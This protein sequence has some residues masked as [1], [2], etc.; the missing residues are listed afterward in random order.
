MRSAEVVIEN[1]A[2]LHSRPG[3]V[4][5]ERAKGWVSTIRIENLSRGA[6][7]VD[8]KSILGLLT[9]GASRGHRM[10]LTVDGADEELALADLV[11]LIEEGI[12]EPETAATQKPTA[13]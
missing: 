5:V 7:P 6:G 12:G 10:R 4:F 9:L 11:R 2:G 1:D 8:A 3:K 13:T